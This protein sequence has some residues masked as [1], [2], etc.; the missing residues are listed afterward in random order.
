MSSTPQVSIVLAT[1]NRR[2]VAVHTV[3][4]LSGCGLD[5]HDYE[6]IVVDNASTDGTPS[7]V[8]PFADRVIALTQ[9]YGSCAKAWGVD[10]A[11][12]RYVVFLDDDSYPQCGTLRR[13]IEHFESDPKLAAAGFRVHLPDGSQECGALPDVFVGCGVGLRAL[14]LR[15]VGGLDRTLFMQAEEYDL[16]FRLAAAGFNVRT[17]DDLHVD[18][19]KTP[20]ARRHERTTYFDTRNN[21]RVIARYL[22]TPA[23]RIYRADALQRYAWIAQNA[24]HGSAMMRGKR[25]AALSSLVERVRYR[26]HRLT[27]ETFE[28]FFQWST[29]EQRMTALAKSGVR[30]VAFVELGKNIY[31]YR[32][33][34]ERAGIPVSAIGDDRFAQPDR[35]YREIPVLTLANALETPHDAVVVSNMAPVFADQAAQAAARST[36]KPVLNWFGRPGERRDA[37]FRS[38]TP[39]KTSDDTPTG[40]VTTAGM[41]KP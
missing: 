31:A 26:R 14:A 36:A 19:L 21:L 3:R 22:P 7:A 39:R 33:A 9:N 8:A 40:L 4:R 27:P 24:G 37:E 35:T 28:R 16:S 12:G 15:D 38:T 41:G 18:H 30:R 34:A 29:V 13:M 11:R 25:A 20:Q 5:R 2:E 1:H 23:W 32:R 6:V 10:V 17:F